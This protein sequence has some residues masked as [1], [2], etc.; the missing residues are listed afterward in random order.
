MTGQ[1][2]TIQTQSLPW[3]EI[4]QGVFLKEVVTPDV[5]DR[6]RTSILR[7]DPHSE[8]FRD[9]I[10]QLGAAGGIPGVDGGW[11]VFVL[12]GSLAGLDPEGSPPLT[13][14][15]Y[16]Q[17]PTW[18][19]QLQGGPEG[20]VCFV[21]GWANQGQG[22]PGHGNSFDP[23]LPQ[24]CPQSVTVRYS[25]SRWQPGQGGLRVLPLSAFGTEGTA[26]V[27]WPAGERFVP[28]QHMGGEEIL[29][30]SG[31]FLD[32][33]G[34]YPAGTWIRS[35]HMSRHHPYVEEETVILVKTGHLR[36]PSVGA[37]AFQ[38]SR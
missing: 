3:L 19:A 27:H 20:C 23:N 11:E 14:W 22:D 29:V 6:F 38:R 30:L 31:T 21:K 36:V 35:P 24:H 9:G 12:E 25:E 28:H 15:D 32:E 34:E 26:L 18:P 8:V 10:V 16:A 1:R 7:L 13:R 2:L 37:E 5:E 33:H 4:S 17:V